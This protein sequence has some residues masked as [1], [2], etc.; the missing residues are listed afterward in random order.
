MI[1]SLALFFIVL[2][3]L[4]FL[5]GYLKLSFI[6]RWAKKID[7]WAKEKKQEYELR[8]NKNNYAWHHIRHPFV[9]VSLYLSKVTKKYILI[10][11]AKEQIL[12][13]LEVM[14]MGVVCR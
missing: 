6:E 11:P 5:V 7:I 1:Y 10:H 9:V 4:V 14:L 12:L 13:V 3:A 2:F 8:G